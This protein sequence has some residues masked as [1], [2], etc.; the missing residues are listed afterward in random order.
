MEVRKWVVKKQATDGLDE[1]FAEYSRQYEARYRRKI[2]GLKLAHVI[3]GNLA[4]LVNRVGR[5]EALAAVKAVFTHPKLKWVSSCP[6]AFLA[7]RDNFERYL[8]PV[9]AEQ[10]SAG[11]QSEWRGPK[12]V[13]ESQEMS[14]EDFANYG[15]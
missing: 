9:L 6:D 4:H 5:E 8:V 7:S 13:H 11:E 12:D 3:R 15:R 10:V 14:P 1:V 2:R